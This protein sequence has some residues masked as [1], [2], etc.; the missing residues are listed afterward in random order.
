[1]KKQFTWEDVVLSKPSTFSHPMFD[2][3]LRDHEGQWKEMYP[4][5][6][7]SFEFWQS[8]PEAT[9]IV[10]GAVWL[11]ERVKGLGHVTILNIWMN[12]VWRVDVVV[13]D[14]FQRY[15]TLIHMSQHGYFSMLYGSVPPVFYENPITRVKTCVYMVSLGPAMTDLVC[16]KGN[17][18]SQFAS[19]SDSDVEF[20]FCREPSNPRVDIVV[21]DYVR[22]SW[23]RLSYRVPQN[24][25]FL[26]INYYYQGA[27]EYASWSFKRHAE[28]VHSIV[29]EIPK[30]KVLIGPGDGYGVLLSTGRKCIV[31]D[32]RPRIGS[33]PETFLQTM[34]RGDENGVLI[35]SYVISLM[36]T[37]TKNFL[38]SWNGPLVI[39]DSHNPSEVL[40]MK[41]VSPGIFV[42]NFPWIRYDGL[43]LV[44][45]YTEPVV[46][47]S[48]NLLRL[49]SISDLTNNGATRYWT[50]MR[51][52][53]T[54]IAKAALV[55]ETLSE[56]FSVMKKYPDR[57]PWLSPIGGYMT[58]IQIPRIDPECYLSSRSVYR[59]S[60]KSDLAPGFK[61]NSHWTEEKGCMYFCFSGSKKFE[62]SSQ[63]S[64]IHVRVVDQSVTTGIRLLHVTKRSIIWLH[65]GKVIIWEK[66]PFT[67]AVAWLYLIEFGVGGWK[68]RLTGVVNYD[69]KL[70]LSTREKML[71][72]TI[73]NQ[74]DAKK[75]VTPIGW[76][77][78]PSQHQW[79]D[80]EF[81]GWS[82]MTLEYTAPLYS[83]FAHDVTPTRWHAQSVLSSMV[84]EQ[85]V[86]MIDAVVKSNP[87]PFDLP[88]NDITHKLADGL[89]SGTQY[90]G[91]PRQPAGVP[92]E[93]EINKLRVPMIWPNYPHPWI[94]V[95]ALP[96][97]IQGGLQ[98]TLQVLPTNYLPL[99]D[100][101]D[102][103]K[104][105][106][107]NDKG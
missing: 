101:D 13:K 12:S 69:V 31:G 50:E 45:G 29:K 105:F 90:V 26:D 72:E 77:E 52:F 57:I 93:A 92:S 86:D 48:E 22:L 71:V 67:V 104:Y 76:C 59:I 17:I 82:F 61:A 81:V 7:L 102:V 94:P 8:G 27:D 80:F 51:P 54:R 55:V 66:T 103:E 25:N 37:E 16:M 19:V 10:P 88:I 42:R 107:D 32:L 14:I 38:H 85:D 79:A 11:G 39:I 68:R 74:A 73:Q 1:M 2:S 89:A 18:S 49:D 35:L 43:K 83:G 65:V 30:D 99:R 20:L 21:S 78:I 56:M 4:I 33:P 100:D 70:M 36:D 5:T 60:A 91:G 98:F 23:Q 87:N 96:P 15:P 62:I 40:C 47:F 97:D 53:A 46:Q 24:I 63:H 41:Q 64:R 106:N 9:Q 6:Q 28:Q 58:E 84:E 3:G 44:E 75:N 95:D 34:K